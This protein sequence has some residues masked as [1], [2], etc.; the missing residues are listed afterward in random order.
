MP[1]G[2]F[3]DIVKVANSRA[4]LE[5]AVFGTVVGDLTVMPP[6]VSF[7]IVPHHASV[8]RTIRL[9]NS[10][11][12]TV[13]VIGVSSTSQSVMAV[14]EAVTPGKVY[15]ITLQLRPNTPDGKLL[16]AL[17]IKTD[18]PQQQTLQVPFYGIVGSFKG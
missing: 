8:L 4:P 15:R 5:I 18:D 10:G 14:V 6:Q 2:P 9:T 7:G 17:A 3:N 16:G 1:A 12:R 11:D 13:K